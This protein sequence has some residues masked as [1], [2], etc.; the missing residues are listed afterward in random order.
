[1]AQAESLSDL[2]LGLLKEHRATVRQDNVIAWQTVAARNARRNA[3][4]N[5][6]GVLAAIGNSK[7]LRVASTRNLRTNHGYLLEGPHRTNCGFEGNCL[8]GANSPVA[9]QKRVLTH[10]CHD[11]LRVL[12][13]GDLRARRFDAAPGAGCAD[14]V[15]SLGRGGIVLSLIISTYLHT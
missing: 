1:M 4:K 8:R 12:P 13:F 6:L 9:A 15:A 10:C 7:A 3:F 5:A 11:A 2:E 14:R